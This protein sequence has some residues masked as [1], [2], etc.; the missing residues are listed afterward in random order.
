MPTPSDMMPPEL[1]RTIAE[2]YHR[3]PEEDRLKQG[4]FILEE[5][6]TRELIE[7]HARRP[8]ATVL[9]VGGAGGAY[10]LWLADAGYT[11]HLM[12]P[13][14]RLVAEA[15]R[16]SAARPRPLASCRVGDA[17]ALD[18]PDQSADLVLLL[19]PLYHLTEA[20]DRACVLS[21]AR[22]VLKPGGRLF[23]AAIS[24]WASA[25]DGLSRDLFQDPRFAAIVERDLHEGQHRNPTERL[26][27]F[28]TAYFHRPDELRAEVTGAGLI[29]EG[30]YGVEGPGWILPDV[31]ARLADSRRRADLLQVARELESEPS[32]LGVSAHLLAVARRPA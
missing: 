20:A 21:E 14:P 17:R 31:A 22:R 27:Y 24:R 13:V 5:A 32:L 23:A 18:F 12:D 1:D 29:V 4:P 25:L 16:R 30:L 3:T 26:D 6:R 11:V 28:T 19:G 10:S 7:R 8:P 9:D 2:F 15:E